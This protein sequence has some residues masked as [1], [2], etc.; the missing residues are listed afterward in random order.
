[1]QT[2]LTI[3]MGT[4]VGFILGA[5]EMT[6]NRKHFESPHTPYERIA[7]STDRLQ[8]LQVFDNLHSFLFGELRADHAVSFRTVV[9]FMSCI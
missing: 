2:A 4:I 6:R 5:E 3:I 7:L 9:E 1:V 8:R